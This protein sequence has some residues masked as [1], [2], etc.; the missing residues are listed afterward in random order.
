MNHTHQNGARSQRRQ[1]SQTVSRRPGGLGAEG[2]LAVA[3]GAGA[4]RVGA[5][6]AAAARVV[7]PRPRRMNGRTTFNFEST[8]LYLR[9]Q[10]RRLNSGPESVE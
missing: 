10:L 6:Y 5:V 7:L 2:T 1:R 8:Q 4:V 3:A 9:P